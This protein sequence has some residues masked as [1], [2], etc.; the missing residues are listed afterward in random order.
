MNTV[1]VDELEVREC[2]PEL[3][4]RFPN[5]A[6]ARVLEALNTCGMEAEAA[7]AILLQDDVVSDVVSGST[8][9]VNEATVE[10]EN[11]EELAQITRDFR[12]EVQV[13]Y[14]YPSVSFYAFLLKCE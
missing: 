2:Y 1:A 3:F 12:A 14:L 4:D 5:H 7:V 13:L 8:D 9:S 6:Y 11:P 10:D